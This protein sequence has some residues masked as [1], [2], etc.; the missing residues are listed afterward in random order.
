[1]ADQFGALEYK[2]FKLEMARHARK[3]VKD[4]YVV[5][6]KQGNILQEVCSVC[7][8]VIHDYTQWSKKKWEDIDI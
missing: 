3:C 8:E 5:A 7:G 2:E 4:F 1:M 6:R